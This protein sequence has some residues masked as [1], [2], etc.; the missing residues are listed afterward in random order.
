[1]GYV[2]LQVFVCVVVQDWVNCMVVWV[3]CEQL[4]ESELWLLLFE[5][6][7]ECV[8]WWV[9]VDVVYVEVVSLVVCEVGEVVQCVFVEVCELIECEVWVLLLLDQGEV[10]VVFVVQGL[11]NVVVQFVL[12]I[13]VVLVELLLCYWCMVEL[14][15]LVQVW[16]VLCCVWGWLC[17]FGYWVWKVGV[18]VVVFVFVVLLFVLVDDCVIVNIVIEGCMCQFVIVFFEGFIVEVLV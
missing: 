11:M 13:S 8:Y 16:C 10:V 6:C 18:V 5:V 2:G 17:G 3:W 4:L 14:L 7:Q 15:L 1:M 9:V 12:C